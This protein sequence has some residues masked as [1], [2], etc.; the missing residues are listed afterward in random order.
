MRLFHVLLFV[1]ASCFTVAS[2]FSAE[3]KETDKPPYYLTDAELDKKLGIDEKTESP[4][5]YIWAVYFHRVPGCDTCQL[6]S[7]YIYET[8]EKRFGDDVKSRNI[9]LRYRNFEEKNNAALVKKLGI[10][11]PSLAVIQI[12]DGK[13]VKAKLADK[14]WSLAA[15]KEKFLDYVEKEIKVYTAE[16]KKDKKQ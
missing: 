5:E 8:I 11:T 2:V 6:M 7:K 12:K 9:V 13:M 14:I 1:L 10:K 3:K 16:L 15:E 4:K